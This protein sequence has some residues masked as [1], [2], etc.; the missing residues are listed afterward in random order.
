MSMYKCHKCDSKAYSKCVIQR[1]IFPE[2]QLE[3]A[4]SNIMSRDVEWI[5]D[6]YGVIKLEIYFGF[7][8]N[9]PE[10]KRNTVKAIEH[11]FE[12]I[13]SVDEETARVYACDHKWEIEEGECMFGCCRAK[14]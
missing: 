1:T 10:N 4:L 5:S 2:N 9:V 3:A 11:A 12:L 7:P 14:E 8:V 13:R 6:F